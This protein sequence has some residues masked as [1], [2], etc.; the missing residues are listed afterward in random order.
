MSRPGGYSLASY[1]RMIDCEPRMG[2]YAEALR[3]AVTPGCTV[4]D[5]GASFGAFALLACQYGAG[6]VIAIEPDPSI[7]L[8]VPLA[9]ANGC[10]DRITIIRDISAN[11]T[12]EVKADVIVSDCRGTVPLFQHHIATLADA[13]A[14]LLAPGGT[15]LPMRDTLKIALAQ[16]PEK[17]RA[18][19]HPWQ[20]NAYGLDLAAGARFA[21]NAMDKAYLK[22]RALV[23][24]PVDLAV[25]DYRT[26]TEPDIDSRVTMVAGRAGRV[27]GILA[28]FEAEIAE[29]LGYSNAPGEPPL[30]YGQMFLPLEG[31]PR[32]A[33]GERIDLRFRGTLVDGEYVWNWDWQVFDRAGSPRGRVARQSTFL[34]QVHS[35]KALGNAS[36]QHVPQLDAAIM[37]D[38]DC[39]AL[40]GEGRTLDVIAKTLQDRHPEHLPTYKAALDHVVK[41][42]GRY[43]S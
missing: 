23:S 3:R 25:L 19:V 32:L 29:G 17:Y 11:Y 8:L 27:D 16:S 14:R 37:L 6:Q 9:R 20:R 2:V 40:V 4:I 30:V 31:N 22:P 21:A 39:L 36:N 12:P 34:A 28:W 33:E 43:R 5:L 15:L 13:R 24:A 35:T 1:G 38:R 26:I 41:C 10:E 18:M 7:E 42:L